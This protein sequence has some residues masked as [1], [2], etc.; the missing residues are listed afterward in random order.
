MEA[1]KTLLYG[2]FIL[3][4]K[5]K[6]IKTLRLGREVILNIFFCLFLFR[7]VKIKKINYIVLS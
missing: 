7:D 6:I 2:F 4:L 5:K 3:L 1:F